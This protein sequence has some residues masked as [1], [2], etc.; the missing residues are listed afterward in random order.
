M[1]KN[2]SLPTPPEERM[3]YFL[4]N[5]NPKHLK[6]SKLFLVNGLFSTFSLVEEKIT[7]TDKSIY[8]GDLKNFFRLVCSKRR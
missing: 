7:F 2:I 5:Y 3:N 1:L 8:K 6:I 4:S